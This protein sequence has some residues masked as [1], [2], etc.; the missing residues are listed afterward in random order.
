MGDRRLTVGSWS[1]LGRR[2]LRLMEAVVVVLT[3]FLGRGK[4]GL[5]IDVFG[6]GMGDRS[7][8]WCRVPVVVQIWTLCP[9]CV[10]Q[11]RTLGVSSFLVL[12]AGYFSISTGGLG[13]PLAAAGKR[14]LNHV[15][16]REKVC[17]QSLGC[18][19]KSTCRGAV[20]LVLVYDAIVGSSVTHAWGILSLSG[21]S[22]V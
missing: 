22:N 10:I 12:L 11:Y 19:T 20:G 4:W 6:V 9:V 7:G 3:S 15:V 17:E 14:R 18:V 2:E 8:L 13:V 21:G 1:H 16:K 5:Q